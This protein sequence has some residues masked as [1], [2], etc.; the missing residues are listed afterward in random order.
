MERRMRGLV[1]GDPIAYAH[2]HGAEVVD[3]AA[4][5]QGQLSVY[6]H[7]RAT[8]AMEPGAKGIGAATDVLL[9]RARM[10]HLAKTRVDL[11]THPARLALA[12]VEVA[13]GSAF[14]P[15]TTPVVVPE[16]PLPWPARHELRLV[17]MTLLGG[18][19]VILHATEMAELLPLVPEGAIE[20]TEGL[21]ATA[22]ESNT[23]LVRVFATGA[24]YEAFR[25]ALDA[26]KVKVEGGPIAHRLSVPY[27]FTARDVLAIAFET[28]VDVLEVR[29]A[30]RPAAEHAEKEPDP[31]DELEAATEAA[32]SAARDRG[33]AGSVARN[34]P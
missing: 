34:E 31:F 23:L 18:G 30:P 25:A 15:R 14:A 17:A 16:P 22:G 4:E 8:L 19:E 20:T 9:R 32:E 11:L 33:Q 3:F 7:V 13:A 27:G 21:R 28:E 12:L 29:P 1:G 6:D 24:P 2:A 5:R 26:R 10:Q